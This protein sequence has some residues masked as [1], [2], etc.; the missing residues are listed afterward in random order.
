MIHLS[1]TRFILYATGADLPG[2][3]VG[4][5]SLELENLTFDGFSDLGSEQKHINGQKLTIQHERED[6]RTSVATQCP[7]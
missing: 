6:L 2:A 3:Q 1:S 7:L 4:C 5:G